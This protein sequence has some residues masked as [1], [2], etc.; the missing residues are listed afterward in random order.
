MQFSANRSAYSDMPSEASQSAIVD[1]TFNP[2]V[3]SHHLL[4]WLRKFAGS[5]LLERAS[6]GAETPPNADSNFGEELPTDVTRTATPSRWR[7]RCIAISRVF[8][9]GCNRRVK[10]YKG[11]QNLRCAKNVSS[12]TK[13]ASSAEQRCCPYVS[14]CRADE[15]TAMPL[16]DPQLPSGL[17]HQC[18]ATLACARM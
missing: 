8:R 7:F 3:A 6:R 18:S 5:G 11:K 10:L 12:R 4:C 9:N 13:R 14:I 2:Q 1:K 17:T 15:A 16:D